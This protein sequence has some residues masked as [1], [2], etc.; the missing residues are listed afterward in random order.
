MSTFDF[1]SFSEQVVSSL[2]SR[3][4]KTGEPVF[5]EGKDVEHIYFCQAGCVRLEVWPEPEKS[6]V[7]YRAG[8]NEAFG[9]EHLMLDKYTYSAV[10]DERSAIVMAPKTILL[11]DILANPKIGYRYV[12]CLIR[13]YYELRVNF[14]RLGITSA[15]ARVW[16]LLVS[17]NNPNDSS[18]DLTGK[19]KSLSNDLNLSHEA[20]YRALKDLERD[21]V[22]QR[23]GGR[24]KLRQPS[25][26]SPGP[27][28]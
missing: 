11:N 25:E 22:L 5:T 6:L 14:E 12:Q 7:L 1:N 2:R 17:L 24:V 3:D 23:T 4:L 9:E 28:A 13:R 15:K 26:I 21:G 20:V 27:N 10:A 16:H 18:I 8:A 19:I